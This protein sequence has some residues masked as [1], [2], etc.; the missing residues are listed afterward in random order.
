MFYPHYARGGLFYPRYARVKQLY[1]PPYVREKQLSSSGFFPA[2]IKI[3]GHGNLYS[4]HLFHQIHSSNLNCGVAT[5][6]LLL[7]RA[8]LSVLTAM[9]VLSGGS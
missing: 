3:P 9:G 8:A 6:L 1:P 5:D 2:A 4:F 7:I